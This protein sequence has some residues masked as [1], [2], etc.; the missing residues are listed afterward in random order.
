MT[1][2]KAHKCWCKDLAQSDKDQVR[3]SLRIMQERI[4][5][6]EVLP[7]FQFEYHNSVFE[8]IEK[9][10][11]VFKNILASDEVLCF[12]EPEK[13]TPQVISGPYRCPLCEGH[14][15]VMISDKTA[16]GPRKYHLEH[17]ACNSCKGSGLVWR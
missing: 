16:D 7:K 2:C 9:I 11:K 14:G 12:Q 8:R 1:D 5:A 4:A 10:E 6:L 13:Q 17:H 15:S 3:E